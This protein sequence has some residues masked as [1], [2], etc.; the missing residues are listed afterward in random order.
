MRILQLWLV[1]MNDRL[2]KPVRVRMC[3][4]VCIWTP[5]SSA[6]GSVCGCGCWFAHGATQFGTFSTL[7]VCMRSLRTYSTTN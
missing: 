2:G 1:Y 7:C 5:F 6:S 4:C 3:V